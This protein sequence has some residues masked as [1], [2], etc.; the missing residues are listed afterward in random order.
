MWIHRMN[1]FKA[2]ITE[3]IMFYNRLDAIERIILKLKSKSQYELYKNCLMNKFQ[4]VLHEII[5]IRDE[6]LLAH[7]HINQLKVDEQLKTALLK[8]NRKTIH[9]LQQNFE[10]EFRKE[11]HFV[12]IAAFF[13]VWEKRR[14]NGEKIAIDQLSYV[15]DG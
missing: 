8:F 3:A 5:T 4:A 10:N 2:D 14:G 6:P 7:K 9:E 12:K 1:N 13:S 11:I 15:E